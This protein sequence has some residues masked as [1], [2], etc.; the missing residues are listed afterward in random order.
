MFTT[1]LTVTSQFGFCGLP[2]RLDSYAGCAFQCTFCF[3]RFRPGIYMIDT[4]R[5]AD[6]LTLGRIFKLASESRDPKDGFVRQFLRRRVPVH[7]G[8]MSDPFQP[9]ELR[10]RVTE[11]FLRVLAK[12]QYP[13]VISTRGTLVAKEP[14]L[15]LLKENRSTVVQISFCSTRESVS[16]RF[17]PNSPTPGQLLKTML[18]LAKNGIKVACRWQP[19]I[20]GSSERPDEFASRVSSAGCR[21]VALEHL[22]LPLE[23]RH[24][25]WEKLISAAGLDL[26][27]QYETLNAIRDSREYVLPPLAKLRIILETFKAVRSRNMTF[28]AADNEFQYLSDC[29]CCCS[30][31]D[32]FPGF[33]N[34]FKHQIGYAVRKSVGKRITYDAIAREWTP[35]GSIDRFINPNSRLSARSEL[36]GS[37]IDHIRTRWNNPKASGSP[38]SFYGV[39]ATADFTSTGNR[40]YEWDDEA[41][42]TLRVLKST[43]ALSAN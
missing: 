22:K 43:H 5:P 30:G 25:M 4:V 2:L 6:P 40:I 9:A 28:G 23:R 8:G 27:L 10:Y 16:R 29:D 41:C 18:T 39:R 42:E 17:E 15:S 1:P 14:Y 13:T 21:H 31:A 19:Y 24:P 3:A 37:V 7:F 34:W 12:N 20:P 11:S 38:T 33:E 36:Q 35:V 32:Q 26:R